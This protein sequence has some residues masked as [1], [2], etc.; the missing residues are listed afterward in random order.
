MVEILW[1]PFSLFRRGQLLQT[2]MR[3]D[4][5]IGHL[6][7]LILIGES[8]RSW[9]T[10][11]SVRLE[12]GNHGVTIIDANR[13]R[14]IPLHCTVVHLSYISRKGLAQA[15]AT[16]RVARKYQRMYH[17]FCLVFNQPRQSSKHGDDGAVK[18]QCLSSVYVAP[19]SSSLCNPYEGAMYFPDY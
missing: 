2:S 9:R 15:M 8:P 7:K 3:H 6:E 16:P 11:C 10:F 5:R 17:R 12:A 1:L 14:I 4:F 18:C 19:V 13:I